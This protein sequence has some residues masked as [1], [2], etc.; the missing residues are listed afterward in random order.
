MVDNNI[1]LLAQQG[2]RKAI[3]VIY[4]DFA[5]KAFVICLRYAKRREDAEDMLQ[6]GF[7]KI[8]QNIKQFDFKGNFE[9]WMRRVM[10]HACI[11]FLGK[12]EIYNDIEQPEFTNLKTNTPTIISE[13]S[14][15]EILALIEK[16]PNGYKLVFNMYVLDG[17][18][19]AEIAAKLSITE[20]TS[21]SQL[22]KARR[23]L[24]S[25]LSKSNIE[26]QTVLKIV[27]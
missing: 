14:E 19:H 4:D 23:M 2:N 9:G 22:V 6:E 10:V 16:L 17:Y 13:L 25:F 27:E 3:K 12:I 20:S 26:P 18:D 15:M 1:I 11:R 21:R 5:G 24:Q 8:F 7:V